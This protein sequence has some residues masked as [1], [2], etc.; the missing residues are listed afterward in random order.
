MS[1]AFYNE[2]NREAAAWLRELI[3]DGCIAPGVVDE[4]SISDI[5]PQ[6]LY[7][8]TQCHFFA[9]IGGWSL[10]LRLA[11]WP[12]S[13]PIWTGSCP[14]QPFSA[15]GKRLGT[16]DERH[17]WPDFL[18]LV[19]QCGPA[20]LLGE[21]VASK[22]GREWLSGVFADLERLD[23]QRAGADLCAAG[24]GAPHIRQR[25]YWL[26]YS[27][28]KRLPQRSKPNCGPVGSI[29]KSSR[30]SDALRRSFTGGLAES[31]SER[32]AGVES[33]RADGIGERARFGS[34]C[35]TGRL[36]D[37]DGRFSGDA[38]IQSGREFGLYTKDCG[39]GGL[40]HSALSASSRLGPLSVE[41]SGS[42][43]AW[44]GFD[45]IQCTDGKTRRIESG[46]FPLAHGISG[47]VGLLRGYGNAI[48]P[49]L[50]AEF[51]KASLEAIGDMRLQQ[52]RCRW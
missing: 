21:Q 1:L 26:A 33:E 6:E 29:W 11:G 30:W 51:I 7:G 43:A 32:R 10:A 45:L 40:E 9:G 12:D 35:T 4:R 50:A 23:Y 31:E 52:Q 49:P 34:D 46:S 47:R 16:S 28:R 5:K 8:F 39:A 20:M 15:A 3:K 36:A 18:W 37:A 38:G 24:V 27:N 44:S 25:L 22:A 48:I 2:N 14:C 19:Q 13:W 41:L 17:L 42:A